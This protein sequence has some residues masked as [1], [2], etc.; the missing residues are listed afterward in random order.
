MKYS[1]LL[2][3]LLC[4]LPPAQA[5]AVLAAQA[6][7]VLE[8]QAPTVNAPVQT[9]AERRLDILRP[10]GLTLP[11]PIRRWDNA[12]PLGNGLTGGLLWGEGAELRL[13]LDR[14]DL[15][16]ERGNADVYDPARNLQTKLKSIR[17]RDRATWAKY[18]DDTYHNSPWTKIP[19]AR[20][21]MTLPE[22]L[23]AERF[24]LA[25]D[26]ALAS[27]ALNAD[28]APNGASHGTSHGTS[29]SKAQVFFSATRPLALLRLPGGTR[30]EL[31]RPASIDSLGYPPPRIL[32]SERAGESAGERTGENALAFVQKTAEALEYAFAIEWKPVDGEI[33][34]ALAATTS[35]EAADP[36]A[37]ARRLAQNGLR[38]GW[39]SALSAHRAWWRDFYYTSQVFIPEP[40]LQHHYNLVKYFY[41]AASRAH[42]AP[43]PLQGV[44]TADEGALPPWKGDYH[45]DLNTQMSYVA[46][47]AAGLTEAGMAY[48]NYYEDRL[49]QFRR[50][51][52]QFFG[53]E[54]AVVPGVMTLKGQ[55]MG[56]WGQYAMSI[57]AGLWNGHAFYQHWK[58][59]GDREF[60]RNRAYPWLAEVAAAILSLAVEKEGKLALPYSSSPEFNDSRFEAYLEPNSNFDQALLTWAVTALAEM[61]TALEKHRDAEKWRKYRGKMAALHVDPETKALKISANYRYEHSHRHFSHTLAIH[62]L[63]ILNV[64]QSPEAREIVRNSVRQILTGGAGAWTGYSYT[65]AAS[66]AARAGFPGAAARLLK[67]F[68]RAFVARNGFHVNGDQTRS[69]LSNFHYRPFTLEGNFLFM[70]AVHEMYL[71]SWGGKVRIFPA[72]PDTWA[73]GEFVDLRA[74][75]GFVVSATRRDSKTTAVTVKSARGGVLTLKNPFGEER[76][77][78]SLDYKQEGEWLTFSLAENGVLKLAPGG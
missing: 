9:S 55:A 51:G 72:V 50:Y 15:W 12:L 52:R 20:L 67:D 37:Y 11:A 46:W 40:R 47:Q 44:W 49:P 71:Q 75:G 39:E 10:H 42:A 32:T 7:T 58:T 43:M 41:G 73:D 38:Q 22:G 19:G 25:F 64:E 63:G 70:D 74:E 36:L 16:D 26:A 2:L 59:S 78:A 53:A 62:P 57:T 56:G 24:S 60:L 33:L 6:P 61:A 31:I 48:I 4:G 3:A 65:W 14:G 17:E 23:R 69:G 5:P 30:F 45:N 21:V 77:R 76:F 13:S 8:A 18:F 66:L 28:G 27:V 35:D 54:G 1:A 29:N 34:A 68:E